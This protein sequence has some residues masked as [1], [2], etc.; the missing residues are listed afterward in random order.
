MFLKEFFEKANFEKKSAEDNRNMKKLPS[1]QS[2]NKSIWPC[3][4]DVGMYH[5]SLK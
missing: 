4:L 5:L 2:V 3:S 1:L